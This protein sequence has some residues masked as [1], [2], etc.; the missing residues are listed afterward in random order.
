VGDD[1]FQHGID[2]FSE[3]SEST[4]T[5]RESTRRPQAALHCFLKKML[6]SNKTSPAC[7]RRRRIITTPEESGASI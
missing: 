6:M 1:V 3:G 4:M 5:R 2:R 7:Q